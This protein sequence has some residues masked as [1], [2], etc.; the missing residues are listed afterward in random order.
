MKRPKSVALVGGGKLSS[1]SLARFWSL[2]EMLGP[3]KASSYR[4]ASRIANSLRAGHPVKNYDEFDACRLVLISVPDR[5]LPSVIAQL[6]SAGLSWSGKSVLLCSACRSSADLREFSARGASVGSITPIPGFND[7]RYLVEGD[8]RAIQESKRL[9]ENQERRCVA[10]E[11]GLKP[12]FLAALTCTGSL[13]IPLIMTASESLRHAG[14][15]PA[16]AIDILENQLSR[17]LRAYLRGGRRAYTPPMEF[18]IQALALA[19]IDPALAAYF[20]QNCRFTKQLLEQPVSCRGRKLG[21]KAAASGVSAS[22][23]D[24]LQ[25]ANLHAAI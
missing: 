8:K 19:T 5:A 17:G 1:S 2:S 15:P 10:I 16:A 6:C 25:Q 22:P 20:E 12:L 7:L 11:H 24:S 18:P 3:V 13:L 14:V 23:A 9:L 4:L 21:R